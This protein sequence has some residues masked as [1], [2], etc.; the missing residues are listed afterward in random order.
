MRATLS[1]HQPA[2][3]KKIDYYESHPYSA[4]SCSRLS[5]PFRP[6]GQDRAG[7]RYHAKTN[8]CE[9][10]TEETQNGPS[11]VAFNLDQPRAMYD[12]HDWWL[13]ALKVRSERAAGKH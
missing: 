12:A 8:G 1:N 10:V 13:T 3:L 11:A 5:R 4:L 2:T 7:R 6:H 9:V